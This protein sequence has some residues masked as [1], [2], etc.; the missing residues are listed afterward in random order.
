MPK[1]KQLKALADAIEMVDSTE[2]C[3]APQKQLHASE[4]TADKVDLTVQQREQVNAPANASAIVTSSEGRT[5]KH[6]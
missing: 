2:E 1:L 6:K 4:A 5:L 3:A